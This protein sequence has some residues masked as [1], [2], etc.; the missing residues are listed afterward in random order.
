M[1][2]VLTLLSL[3]SLAACALPDWFKVSDFGSI[4]VHSLSMQIIHFPPGWSSPRNQNNETILGKPTREN[5]GYL[6]KGEFRTH[7]WFQ[8][9]E[10]IVPVSPDTIS[11]TATM[12]SKAP[13]SNESCVFS[14]SLPIDLFQGQN[15]L[16]DGTPFRLPET[17]QVVHLVANTPNHRTLRLPHTAGELEVTSKEPFIL[18]VQDNRKFHQSTYTIRI[19]P[20]NGN[21]R[22]VQHLA[23][24]LTFRNIA[25]IQSQPLELAHLCQTSFPLPPKT[26]LPKSKLNVDGVQFLLANGKNNA[27]ALENGAQATLTLPKDKPSFPKGNWLYLLHSCEKM[28]GKG[29]NSITFHYPNGASRTR[30]LLP[31]QDC[32]PLYGSDDFPN[33]VI[34]WRAKTNGPDSIPTYTSLYLSVFDLGNDVPDAIVFQAANDAKW[35]ICAA[36]LADAKAKNILGDNKKSVTAGRDWAVVPTWKPIR[37]GSVLD[38]SSH[39]DKPAGKYGRIIVSQDGHFTFEKKPDARVRLLGPNLVSSGATPPKKTAE[40][41]AVN[42]ARHGY[43]TARFHHFDRTLCDGKNSSRT[44]FDPDALD[45]L[46]YFFSCLKNQGIYLTIDLFSRRS[47][48]PGEIPN[49]DANQNLKAYKGIIPVDD[50]AFE[51]WKDYARTLL[52]HKNPYTGMT[53]AE[54]PALYCINLVNENTADAVWGASPALQK[55]YRARYEKYL[56]EKGI[57]TPQNLARKDGPFYEFLIDIFADFT[58]R[59]TRFLREELHCKALITDANM[60]FNPY[61]SLL[62]ADDCF[63]LVDNHQY[64]SH[65]S[66]P[67]RQWAYPL[68]FAS[69]SNLAAKASLPRQ[70]APT[71][72]YGKPFICTEYQFCHPNRFTAESGPTV[73]AYAALQDWDALYPFAY[74][75]NDKSLAFPT[76]IYRWDNV[77]DPPR[78]F[79]KY[80]VWFAFIRG[81]VQAARQAI[82]YPVDSRLASLDTMP[83]AWSLASLVSRVGALRPDKA[84]T[85]PNIAMLSA[86]SGKAIPAQIQNAFKQPKIVSDTQEIVLESDKQL[87]VSAPKFAAVTGDAPTLQAGPI[88]V[89]DV[90]YFQTVAVATLDNQPIASSSHLLLFHLVETAN[91][92]QTTEKTHPNR[93]IEIGTLPRL[94][95][96]VQS[97]LALQL[98]QADWKVTR[99]QY[100]GTPGAPHQASYTN[101]ELR[102][103]LDSAQTVLYEIRK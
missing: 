37:E 31:K 75:S 103:R 29:A 27:I 101:G 26:A 81:D 30:Q 102:L 73:G 36:S 66:F 48:R 82:A 76:T 59:A 38:F 95:R 34:A 43:N 22:T 84:S 7:G 40:I 20:N 15:I 67:F 35:L 61:L 54:D 41:A 83:E 13:V 19:T 42:L 52:S 79:G 70:M 18:L 72:V 93:L 74:S 28:P 3:V 24:D 89:T 49:L 5:D 12:D 8:F 21:D 45:R 90:N 98:P 14:I 33:A 46:D 4:D 1:K 91:S 56:Q 2:Q 63:E 58:R 44:N 47:I 16:I 77:Q 23:W 68:E 62:R 9:E 97:D 96:R 64:F 60:H 85:M 55:I 57:L 99:V 25:G 88:T 65:P 53:W 94:V 11:Y 32:G 51:N 87:A 10:K 100:D 39:V 92:R 6:L 71:R 78:S 50:V 80:L 17:Y 69:T 86:L